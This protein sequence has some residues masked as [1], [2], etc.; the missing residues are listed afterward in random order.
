MGLPGLAGAPGVAGPPGATGPAGTTGAQGQQ[1]PQGDKGDRGPGGSQFGED[2][3]AFA[4][5]TTLPING[6]L[7]GREQMHAVCNAAFAG[8]HLCHVAEYNLAN[9]STPIPAGGA[10][11]D[12]SATADGAGESS[13]DEIASRDSAR[14]T[15]WGQFNCWSWSDPSSAWGTALESDGGAYIAACTTT[16]VLACCST[17]YQEHFRGFTTATTTGAAGG[18]AQ[19]NYK[20]GQ[21]FAGSHLCHIAEYNR[22]TP[23]TTPPAS[24]AWVDAS[25]FPTPN[26]GQEEDSLASK[27][28][29]RVT[30]PGD[31][32]NCDNWT[33]T[34]I[35]GEYGLQGLTVEPVHPYS[36]SCAVA[37]PLACCE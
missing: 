23:T 4:G 36:V 7:G 33:A 31:Y 29:G 1:G 9:S 2:A 18:R 5:F 6:A 20:C 17:P 35:P 26:G 8:S 14:V 16:H 28:L 25:G 3:A 15:G 27:H 22:A 12:S 10:W 30:G 19:M 32:T 34:A 11:M 24:G 13:S 21:E 37:R